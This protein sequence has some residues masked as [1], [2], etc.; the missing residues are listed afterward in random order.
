V[1]N[2]YKLFENAGVTIPEGDLYLRNIDFLQQLFDLGNYSDVEHHQHMKID[3]IRIIEG[4][5]Q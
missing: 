3:S 2:I 1:D 4:K 5:K